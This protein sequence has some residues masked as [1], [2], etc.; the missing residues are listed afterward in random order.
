M[1][2]TCK[3]LAE[4]LLLF[5]DG[6]LDPERTEQLRQHLHLCPP[7]MDLLH[8]YDEVVDILHELRPEQL[9]DGLLERLKRRMQE[10]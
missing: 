1:G 4:Y 6:E 5:R 3:Q 7:C 10:G 2:F 8:S 9:P